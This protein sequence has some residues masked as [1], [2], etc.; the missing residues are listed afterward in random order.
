MRSGL[1]AI[2]N[3]LGWIA[4]S[5]LIGVALLIADRLGF[6]GLLV[7]GLLVAYVCTQAE[8]DHDVPS[9]G[10]RVM[11][12]RAPKTDAPETETPEQRAARHADRHAALSPLRFVGLCGF[13]WQQWLR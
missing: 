11:R 12:S 13:I 3:T 2:G 8:L 10:R 6:F 5:A 4:V 1:A 9:W 7:L